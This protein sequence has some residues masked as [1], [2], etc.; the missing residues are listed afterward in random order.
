MLFH[1]EMKFKEKEHFCFILQTS[2][3][4]RFRENM[5]KNLRLKLLVGENQEN[6]SKN[7]F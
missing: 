6:V 7:E 3:T 4:L 2:K 5:T 1:I